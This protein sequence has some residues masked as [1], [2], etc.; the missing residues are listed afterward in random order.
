MELISD[1]DPSRYR[2]S[3]V[4]RAKINIDQPGLGHPQHETVPVRGAHVR[5]H[6]SPSAPIQSA[7]QSLPQVLLHGLM[8]P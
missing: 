5:D 6:G 3:T 4:V 2:M 8:R 7:P 1:G